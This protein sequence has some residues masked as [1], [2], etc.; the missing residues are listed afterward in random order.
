MI[1]V[2]GCNGMLGRYMYDYLQRKHGKSNVKGVDR[3]KLEVLYIVYVKHVLEDLI[4]KDDVVINC[5]GITNK[6]PDVSIPDM[7]MVNSV[8]PHILARICTEKQAHLIHPSTDC[9]FSGKKIGGMYTNQDIPDENN[10][11]G[12]SKYIGEPKQTSVIRCSIIGEELTRKT[13]LLEWCKANRGKTVNGFTEH[14]W[15]GMTCLEYTKLVSTIILNNDYWTGIRHYG[16]YYKGQSK[17]SKHDLIKCINEVYNLGMTIVPFSTEKVD[18]TLDC[19]HTCND[20][21]YQLIELEDYKF[22]V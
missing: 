2:L 10:D 8:F 15:N 18:K 3:S 22:S 1:I 5:I 11:Y 14:Y 19:I 16:S 7:Y 6:R 21:A 20:L 9:V 13:G 17:V 12:M 4:N